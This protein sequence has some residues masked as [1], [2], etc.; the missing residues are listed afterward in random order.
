[1]EYCIRTMGIT[2]L[3]T[4]LR[5]IGHDLRKIGDPLQG[6]VSFFGG[7]LIYGRVRSKILSRGLVHSQTMAQSIWEI[8]WLCQLLMEVGIKN[9][10][11]TKLWC[12]KQ[13]AIHIAS[14]PVFHE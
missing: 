2:E 7:N 12:D 4:F 9:S 11:S 5:Q 1:M 13:A 8:M 3:S 14:N 6:I 10:V